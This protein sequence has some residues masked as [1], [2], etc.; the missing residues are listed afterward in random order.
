MVFPS[1][2]RGHQG[3]SESEEDGCKEQRQRSNKEDEGGTERGNCGGEGLLQED[4]RD[5]TLWRGMKTITGHK[6]NSGWVT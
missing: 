5:E 2:N 6:Q 1:V 3:N 4:F